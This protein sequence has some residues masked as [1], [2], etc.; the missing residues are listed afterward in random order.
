MT[1]QVIEIISFPKIKH[2]LYG[3]CKNSV[4]EDLEAIGWTDGNV[5]FLVTL[6]RNCDPAVQLATKVRLNK[7]GNQ[8]KS[9][10]PF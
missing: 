8:G 9:N 2:V 1:V 7:A 3:A 6:C 5:C 4:P 10:E